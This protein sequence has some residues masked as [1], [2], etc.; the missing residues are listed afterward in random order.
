MDYVTENVRKY[1]IYDI[2]CIYEFRVTYI[3][4]S[5]AQL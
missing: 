5:A 4:M 1:C 2:L 3:N